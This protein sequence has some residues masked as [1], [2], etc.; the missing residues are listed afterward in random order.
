MKVAVNMTEADL[1]ALLAAINPRPLD[2]WT[3][4]DGPVLWWSFPVCEPP[5]VGDP[6]YDDFPDG[7]THWTKLLVPE[8]P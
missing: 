8:E 7:V 1:A 4:E 6:L 3:E 2:E 5:Y